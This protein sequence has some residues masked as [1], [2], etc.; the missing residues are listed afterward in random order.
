MVFDREIVLRDPYRFHQ[1]EGGSC[2]CS[3]FW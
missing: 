1:F 3:D 2:T